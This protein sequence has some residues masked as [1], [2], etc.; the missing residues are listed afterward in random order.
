MYSVGLHVSKDLIV[1]GD[2]K[3]FRFEIQSAGDVT[4]IACLYLADPFLFHQGG[5]VWYLFTKAINNDCQKGEIALSVSMDGLK[6]FQ[7]SQIVLA[8]RW[9]LS[10]PYVIE[11]KGVHYMLPSPLQ[12]QVLWLYESRDGDWPYRWDRKRQVLV[13]RLNLISRPLSPVLF[14]YEQDQTWYLMILDEKLGKERVY[15]SDR[16]DGG[17]VE[18]VQS[19]Q[20]SRR[21]A[22]RMVLKEGSVWA[23]L[24]DDAS[25]SAYAVMAV[26]MENLSRSTFRY[27]EESIVVAGQSS[28]I[29][30]A[31]R[32]MHTYHV[33][34][35]ESGKL[36]MAAV[37]GMF[38]DEEY[39]MWWCLT[40]R[41]QNNQCWHLVNTKDRFSASRALRCD[42]THYKLWESKHHVNSHI[43]VQLENMCPLFSPTD[44][45][46]ISSVLL[47]RY[48]VL[49]YGCSEWTLF[50]SGCV[51]QWLSFDYENNPCKIVQ[52][53]KPEHVK[54]IPAA[55]K[56]FG[57]ELPPS[58]Q[59]SELHFSCAAS[60]VPILSNT[61]DVGLVFLDSR[62][63][64]ACAVDIV[65]WL[66]KHTSVVL[67]SS[68][69]ES[70]WW[71]DSIGTGLERYQVAGKGVGVL[72]L[73]LSE[74]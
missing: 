7:Y 44:I 72:I 11:H 22:G 31:E 1:A 48:V 71:E 73:V 27:S 55:P 13:E 9:H 15:F 8:E 74:S 20:Y 63:G 65:P 17:F 5:D 24:Q 3:D 18:H 41:I 66:S 46:L 62:G 51:T 64:L 69:G 56:L 70:S 36:W 2:D 60:L 34:W 43:F 67:Y 37:D 21:N 52:A 47:R 4:D 12:N 53:V 57:N 61:T 35:S 54:V 38:I 59:E 58:T 32:G 16:I 25:V 33:H 49:E 29:P 40:S 14:Y 50:Y 10:W 6:S 42:C 39:R 23:F 19:K 30:Y 45:G 28:G 68:E 26:R